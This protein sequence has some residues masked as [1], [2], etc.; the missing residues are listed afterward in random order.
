M[1]TKPSGLYDPRYEHDACGVAFV[2]RLDGRPTHEVVQRGVTVVTN[3]EHRGATGADPTTGDG[4]GL[5][6]QMP[7][8]LLRGS[9]DFELPERGRYGVAVCFLPRHRVQRADLKA[10]IEAV[11]AAEGQTPLGWR[12]VPVDERE[13]G[14]TARAVAPAIEQLFIGMDDSLTDELAIERKLYVIRRLIEKTAV[15]DV[16]VASMSSRTMVYKGMLI[17]HQLA[18][19]FA[20]LR[21]ERTASALALVHS[22]FSTNTFPSWPL[23]HPYRFIAHNGEINALMGNQNWMRA[24]ESSLQSELFGDDLEKL[25]PIV[26]PGNSDSATFDNVVELLQL[27]GRSLPHALMMMI[28]EAYEG[29]EDFMSPEVRGFYQYHACLMEPWD[30]PAVIA[31]TDGHLIGATLDRNGLR[32]GRWIETRDGHVVLA[33]ET[34]ALPAPESE[35]VRKGRLHP[36]KLFLVDLDRHRIVDDADIKQEVATRKPYARVV[37][38]RVGA[39]RGP[40]R[41]GAARASHRAAAHA[42]AGVR[43]QPGG[44]ARAADADG[45]RRRRSRRARWATTWRW[46]CSRTARR[47]CSATSSSSSPRSPTRPSTRSARRS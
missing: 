24:R 29:R 8:A 16:H 46:P 11:V 6:M 41:E 10:F 32:P 21:D 34:G 25:A 4:A 39:L 2:A 43:L 14:T 23:A 20:D 30:G 1:S 40:A 7:D 22:R 45:R 27:A 3:L 17:A 42:P 44:P 38:E 35:I 15:E 36:G 47:P 19:F 5:L 18:P 26:Q 33:S 9:V 13:A 37:R 28:P 31:A 12:R